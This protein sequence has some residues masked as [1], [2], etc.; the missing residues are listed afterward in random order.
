MS[1]VPVL[2]V[3]LFMFLAIGVPIG[4][5]MGLACV[6]AIKLS[7][8]TIPLMVI[9]Q[10]MYTGLDSF[11]LMA[12][13]FFMLA[14]AIME[15]T[16][17]AN[18]LLEC[19]NALIGH[20]KGGLS[21]VNIVASMFFAGITGAATADTSAIGSVLIPA[22]V[23]DG[24]PIDYSAAVTAISSTIGVIIP[25]SM[26]MV[27]AGVTTGTSIAA[28]FLGGVIPGILSGLAQLV[29]SVAYAKKHNMPARPG[30]PLASQARLL[31]TNLPALGMPFII[32]GGI[33]AGVFTPTEASVIAVIY[34]FIVGCLIEKKLPS[35]AQMG[36]MLTKVSA[37]VSVV[38]LCLATATT[39]GWLLGIAH[40][41][42]SIARIIFSITDN[43]VVIKLLMIVTFLIV[44]TF[45]DQ[46]PAILIFGPI[47]LPIVRN[48]GM[49][50]V[51][52]G[53]VIVFSMAIGL[54][55]PPVGSVLY[56]VCG[57]TGLDML[58]VTRELIPFLVAVIIVLIAI[59]FIPELVLWL[60]NR[61]LLGR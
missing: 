11:P 61:V 24:Y 46:V 41:P 33:M 58:S 22:M 55:T 43:P 19:A 17:I 51:H 56:V 16:N 50:P 44:G 48:L 40:L 8:T 2:I 38:L 37:T 35:L 59:T 4:Y 26:P 53:V 18:R 27:I 28:L 25:P 10:K 6:L 23:K 14:G 3:S 42:A 39:F 31:F 32:I 5:A 1:I 12:M 15:E 7:G 54:V 21:H 45:M 49:S 34:G 20:V 57:I 13:P 47:F 60:P 52:F 29:V 30:V 36:N 9:V